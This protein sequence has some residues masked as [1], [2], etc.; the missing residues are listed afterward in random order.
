M[1][2][3]IKR[4]NAELPPQ[5]KVVQ[6]FCMDGTESVGF[7][8]G[9]QFQASGLRVEAWGWRELD[10]VDSIEASK[11]VALAIGRA[12]SINM[13]GGESAHDARLEKPHPFHVLNLRLSSGEE[14]LGLWDGKNY[15]HH[16]HIVEPTLWTA[17]H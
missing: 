12:P 14:V 8:T 2:P 9:K 3:H 4:A 17:L 11:L 13:V 16:G 7:W 1:V 15:I 5:W 6:L 10:A